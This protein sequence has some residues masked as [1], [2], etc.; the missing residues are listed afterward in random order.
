[1]TAFRSGVVAIVGRP[2]TGKSTLLNRLVGQHVSITSHRA[3]T[4]RFRILGI[5]TMAHAQVVYVDTPGL[6]PPAGRHLS[7][8]MNR[9][10]AGSLEGVDGVILVIESSGWQEGDEYPLELLRRQSRPVILAINKIDIIRDRD[11]LLP[12]LRES[13]GKMNFAEYVPISALKGAGVADLERAVIKHLPEQGPIYAADQLTD[14]SE[15]FLAAE[16]VR[17]Q[18]FRG[19][20]HEVP[21]DAAVLIER[22]HRTRGMLHVA[23]TIVVEKEGQ[24][25]ILIGRGGERLKGV[26]QRARLAMQK[27]FGRKVHLELWVKVRKGWSE[28]ER[29]LRSLGYAEEG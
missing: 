19:F 25:A 23:A 21:Y 9:I 13:S 24:K 15:A 28:S 18:I 20:G 7:R 10:A 22:F 6:H 11:S 14:K 27:L 5:N 17:E 12:L 16:L 26:G 8:Y 2:N 3:Q 1:M 4:T 29:E